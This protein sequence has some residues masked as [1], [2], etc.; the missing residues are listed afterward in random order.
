MVSASN[1]TLEQLLDEMFDRFHGDNRTAL[2][3][4][5]YAGMKRSKLSRGA[6][7]SILLN[8]LLQN[9]SVDAICTELAR[10]QKLGFTGSPI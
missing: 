2:L 3:H 10:L 8:A 6:T 7:N 4:V 9:T 1:L 5:L